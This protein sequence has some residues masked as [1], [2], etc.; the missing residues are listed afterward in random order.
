MLTLKTERLALRPLTTADFDAVHSYASVPEN[1]IYM[2]WGPNSAEDTRAFLELCEAS[3]K[4]EPVRKYEFAITLE[5]RVIGACGLYLRD[6]DRQGE[7]GW[8]LH[9]DYWR[10]GYAAEAAGALLRYGFETLKLHRITANCNAANYGSFK[11]MEKIGMRRESHEV[12]SAYAREGCAEK[13]IDVLRYAMLDSEYEF[14]LHPPKEDGN[15]SDAAM[16]AR[17][18]S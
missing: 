5:G 14:M 11:V 12:R 18:F 10:R 15:A 6:E 16:K 13:W 4:E 2:I 1:V 8:I 3:W 17:R 9:R 7:M